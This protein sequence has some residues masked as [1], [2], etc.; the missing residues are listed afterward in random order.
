MLLGFLHSSTLETPLADVEALG[1]MVAEMASGTSGTLVCPSSFSSEARDFVRLCLSTTKSNPVSLLALQRHP[2]VEEGEG[3]TYESL[4]IPLSPPSS[5]SSF[6]E[7]TS[8]S[9]VP[10]PSMSTRTQH[11]QRQYLAASP[12]ATLAVSP[13]APGG[14]FDW[15]ESSMGAHLQEGSTFVHPSERRGGGLT[16]NVVGGGGVVSSPLVGRTQ[17]QPKPNV[18]R[19][20]RYHTDFEEIETLG[21]GSRTRQASASSTRYAKCCLLT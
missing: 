2:F 21:K 17:V 11:R 13:S 1:R 20:G 19:G 10:A 6:M 5:R 8:P 16:N 14:G 3:N 15:R 9:V 18:R 4:F 7:G 12:G